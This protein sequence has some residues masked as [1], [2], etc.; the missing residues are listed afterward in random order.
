MYVYMTC[1]E[2]RRVC[3]RF[4]SPVLRHVLFISGCSDSRSLCNGPRGTTRDRLSAS[5]LS[6][7][8]RYYYYYYYYCVLLLC[9]IHTRIHIYIYIHSV[10]IIV[11]KQSC[12]SVLHQHSYLTRRAR[13]PQRKFPQRGPLCVLS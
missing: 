3:A 9:Y 5:F 4:L 1:C 6:C 10:S 8:G 13:P 12:L 7:Y 11:V 2:T